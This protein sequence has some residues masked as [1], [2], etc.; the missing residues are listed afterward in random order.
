[1]AR[2][3]SS[4]RFRRRLLRVGVVLAAA[5]VA[6]V[7]SILFWDTGKDY[8]LPLSN[9]PAVVYEQ[10]DQV[11]LPDTER[12]DALRTATQFVQTAVTR[13]RTRESFELVS[14]GLR[15]GLTRQEW[16]TGNIPV[17]PYP[18]DAARWTLDYQYA[19]EIGLQVYVVPK[20]GVE[21][22]PMV[23]LLTMR[24]SP[25]GSW[26]VDSWVPR[27]GSDGSE[28]AAPAASGG[29][30]IV[31]PLQLVENGGKISR[32]WL[33]LPVALLSL[34]FVVPAAVM[35]RERLRVRR[36]ERAYAAESARRASSSSSSPS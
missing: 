26:L 13:E 33:A 17:Q 15:Q 4:P 6:A 31:P 3:L 21:L 11:R 20:A 25:Q 29:N 14:E 23:F 7:V 1:V 30:G 22:R 12:K 32:V 10:P 2:R 8:D 5:C 36:A 34:V 28:T 19:R 35:T 9:R 27:P 24:K 18:V 16:A